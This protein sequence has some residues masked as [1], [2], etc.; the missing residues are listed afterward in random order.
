MAVLFLKSYRA[1]FF[2]CPNSGDSLA[3]FVLLLNKAA[4]GTA[5]GALTPR[6]VLETEAQ[7]L[8]Q[9]QAYSLSHFMFVGPLLSFCCFVWLGRCLQ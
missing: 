1:F 2:F 8:A 9:G 6:T 5:A 4:A 3:V 7:V